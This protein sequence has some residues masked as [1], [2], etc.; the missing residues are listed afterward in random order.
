M[1][2]SELELRS[3]GIGAPRAS[4]IHHSPTTC[5]RGAASVLEWSANSNRVST[6]CTR[7]RRI[8]RPASAG[9]WEHSHHA[10]LRKSTNAPCS[11]SKKGD[12]GYEAYPCYADAA[13]QPK[14]DT[15]MSKK[16][17]DQEFFL[18]Q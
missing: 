15:A 12:R 16:M 18:Y 4:S 11:F 13:F 8:Q 9:T 14:G 17:K 7:A 6:A 10:P 3:G 2:R 1:A 5:G